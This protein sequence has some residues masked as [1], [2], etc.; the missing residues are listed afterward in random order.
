MNKDFPARS[1]TEETTVV[2]IKRQAVH[3]RC[4]SS[5]HFDWGDDGIASPSSF[6]LSANGPQTDDL[7]NPPE[8]NRV[9]S[10]EN[11]S[12]LTTLECPSRSL[13]LKTEV[14]VDSLRWTEKHLAAKTPRRRF[15]PLSDEPFP[16]SSST[17]AASAVLLTDLLAT[18]RPA[19]GCSTGPWEY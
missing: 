9:P 3:I 19:M 12:A 10:S 5:L 7:S 17:A 4:M 18:L 15:R 16:S 11:S 2:R 1:T 13:Q 8:T 14:A 6:S